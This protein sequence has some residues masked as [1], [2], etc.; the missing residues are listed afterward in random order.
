MEVEDI[1]FKFEIGGSNKLNSSSEILK[2]W[3]YEKRKE[4]GRIL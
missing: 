4:F 1:T 2:N 3:N